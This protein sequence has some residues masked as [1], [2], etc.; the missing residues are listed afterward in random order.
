MDKGIRCNLRRQWGLDTWQVRRYQVDPYLLPT[1]LGG[2]KRKRERKKKK[3]LE[4]ERVYLLSKFPGDRLSNSGETR[5][6]VDPH[7]ESY[8]WV[9]VLWSL[10]KLQEVGVFL[11]LGLVLV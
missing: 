11:L 5:G 6:K 7:G 10:K 9:P 4:R 3:I 2:K 1:G 8:T